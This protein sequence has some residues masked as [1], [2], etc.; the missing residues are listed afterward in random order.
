MTLTGNLK[1][2]NPGKEVVQLFVNLSKHIAN[3][4]IHIMYQEH[5]HKTT[6]GKYHLCD[7]FGIY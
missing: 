4:S 2:N 5:M 1:N 3:Q 7:T 6:E